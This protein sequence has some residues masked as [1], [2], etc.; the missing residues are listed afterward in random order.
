MKIKR[1]CRDLG[2][3]LLNK[4]TH[5]TAICMEMPQMFYINIDRYRYE[6]KKCKNIQISNTQISFYTYIYVYEYKKSNTQISFL[7]KLLKDV[8]QPMEKLFK[9]KHSR[10]KKLCFLLWF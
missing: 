9:I 5:P 10:M 2:K 6:C 7:R 8:D 4:D 3:K 1:Q